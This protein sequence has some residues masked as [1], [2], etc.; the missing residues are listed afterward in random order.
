MSLSPAATAPAVH[1]FDAAIALAPMDEHRFQGHTTPDYWNMI[2]PFGGITAATLLQAALRHPARLGDPLALTVNFAGP[3]AEGPFVIAARPVRTNRSTQ[4]WIIELYQGDQLA[5]S[6]TA[7]FSVRRETWACDEAAFP[8]VP[9]PEAIS[10]MQRFAPVRWLQSY[11]IR[12]VRGARPPAEA[13]PEHP[14]SLTQFWLRDHPAR[15]PD[16]AAMAAWCD[17]FYPRIFLKR[18]GF[19][20][21]GTVSMTT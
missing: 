10:G 11:D 13:G 19:V 12:P 8:D 3:I 2:G 6:A 1:P 4:H 9:G 21:A 20:P 18:P 14:D 5:T 7:V 15:T 17:A 16:Y